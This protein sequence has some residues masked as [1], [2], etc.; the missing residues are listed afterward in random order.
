MNAE[1]T[2]RIGGAALSP[3]AAI[4]S[5][6]CALTSP[7]LG[8]DFGYSFNTPP[9]FVLR[10]AGQYRCTVVN[11]SGDRIS[12]TLGMIGDW[13]NGPSNQMFN[14][15]GGS[16]PTLCPP[17]DLGHQV[18]GCNGGRIKTCSCASVNP[19]QS[20]SLSVPLPAAPAEPA[21]PLVCSVTASD[22]GASKRVRSSLTANDAS[23]GD[24]KATTS[25]WRE[26]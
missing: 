25:V 22:N 19:W 8:V 23:T 24:A 11:V 3:L 16:N 26:D 13:S 5:L 21:L 14:C 1:H 4:F 6:L 20:C 17:G 7:V 15:T 9:L 10:S 2:R 18:G 12:I